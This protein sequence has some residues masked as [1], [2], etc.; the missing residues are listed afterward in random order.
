[1]K[2]IYDDLLIL[3]SYYSY[4]ENG[5]PG[6]VRCVV[7]GNE[8]RIKFGLWAIAVGQCVSIVKPQPEGELG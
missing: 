4:S 6:D 5:A 1:M 8:E 3:L 7:F 2:I